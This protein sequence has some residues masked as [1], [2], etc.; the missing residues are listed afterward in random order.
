M[1]GPLPYRDFY[2][3]LN[4]FMHIL[5]LEDGGVDSLHYGL[6]ESAD[7]PLAAAQQRATGLLLARLP[8]PPARILDAGVGLGTT[9]ALLTRLG[10][11]A[12]GITPDEKQIAYLHARYGDAV[13]A[14][15]ARFED[16]RGNFDVIVFQESSQYIHSAALFANAAQLTPRVLVMDEFSID[17]S[18]GLHHP[19]DA[20]LAAAAANGFRVVEEV[21]LSAKAAPTPD[22][23]TA[24]LPR[25]RE[26]LTAALGLTDQQVDELIA[27]G[28]R[29]AANYR[30]GLYSYRLIDLA[31]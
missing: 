6:F 18:E 31:R 4:V 3:P 22:Y 21:D 7:E 27:G 30:N 1:N 19:L 10:H 14:E 9:L 23:F 8:P 26:A 16:F 12:I 24:R 13:R 25:H 15:C 28:K 5:T 29:Y 11:H 2:Y 20:F 17:T